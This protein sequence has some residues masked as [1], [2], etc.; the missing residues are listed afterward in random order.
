[1]PVATRHFTPDPNI[2]KEY[3]ADPVP[4]AVR[5]FTPDWEAEKAKKNAL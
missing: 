3:K 5:H 2:K 4:I 1:M